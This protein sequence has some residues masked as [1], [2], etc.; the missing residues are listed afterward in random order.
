V[1]AAAAGRVAFAGMLT[2]RGN[3]VIVDHGLGVFTA[4]HHLSRIDAARARASRRA[5]SS[6]PLA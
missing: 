6:A 5:R 1:Q 2:T 3:S 4:Y